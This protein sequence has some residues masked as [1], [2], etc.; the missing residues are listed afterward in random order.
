[1]LL[2]INDEYCKVIIIKLVSNIEIRRSIEEVLS[3]VPIIQA[4]FNKTPVNWEDCT[5]PYAVDYPAFRNYTRG[6]NKGLPRD[7]NPN[8]RTVGERV[9]TSRAKTKVVESLRSVGT[10]EQQRLIL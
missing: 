5:P 7:P 3:S 1:M 6:R 8:V 9:A 4:T 10:L 2:N